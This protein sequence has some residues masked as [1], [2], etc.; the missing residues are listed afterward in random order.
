MSEIAAK[1]VLFTGCGDDDSHHEVTP[2]KAGMCLGDRYDRKVCNCTCHDATR[3]GFVEEGNGTHLRDCV[4]PAAHKTDIM[5][6]TGEP[7]IHLMGD[8]R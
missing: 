5:R 8:W 1:L 3:C 2:P 7:A 6:G 4:R